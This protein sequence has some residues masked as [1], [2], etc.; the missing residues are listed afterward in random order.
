MDM[1]HYMELLATN[2]P[3]NLII[4]MAI[5]VILAETIAVTELYILYTRNIKGMIRT[6]NKIAGII[7]GFYFLIVFLHLLS[8]AVIPITASGQWRTVIDVIAVSFYLLGVI[9]LFG[10]TLLEIG[11]I[12]KKKSEEWKL[13]AHATFVAIFLVVAHIAMIFGMLSPALLS[14]GT[15]MHQM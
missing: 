11:A 10:I 2:Q 13:G 8:K 14:G 15:P 6:V 3:W 4:F 1:T 9:P 5:P 12:W 7:A